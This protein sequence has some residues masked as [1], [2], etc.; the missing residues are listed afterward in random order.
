[1]KNISYTRGKGV[2]EEL[3]AKQRARRANSLIPKSY[4]SGRI[5]DIGCGSYPYFLTLTDFK[6]K[7][8]ID[9]SLAS[10]KL[11]NITLE[12]LDIAKN[13]LPFKD[14]FFDTVTMLAVFE[15]IEH[16]KLNFVLNEIRRVLRKNGVF[17]ITT[18]SP[19]GDKL[20]HFMTIF[21]LV[22]AEEIHEHKHKH[23]KEKIESILAEAGFEKRKIKSG[24]FEFFMNMWFTAIK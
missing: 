7:Y 11:E 5:L 14:N 15:H 17:I 21:G 9:P 16:D 13:K 23:P 19:L 10:S 24:F 4:R 18:P 1:M 8:G 2:L 22:S 20:L 6:E 12:K 3:L